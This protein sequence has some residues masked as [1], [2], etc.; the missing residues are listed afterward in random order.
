MGQR[1]GWRVSTEGRKNRKRICLNELLMLKGDIN[2]KLKLGQGLLKKH[3]TSRLHV[4]LCS[5]VCKSTEAG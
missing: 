4:A 1:K 2:K 5:C 3:H